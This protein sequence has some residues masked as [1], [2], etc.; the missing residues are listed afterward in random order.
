MTE[1]KK[2][3]LD[4]TT[5]DPEKWALYKEKSAFLHSFYRCCCLKKIMAHRNPI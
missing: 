3:Q 4:P 1:D 5:L 2:N